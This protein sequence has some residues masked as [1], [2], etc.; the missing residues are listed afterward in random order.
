[1]G[2]ATRLVC[3]VALPR[4]AAHHRKVELFHRLDSSVETMPATPRGAL[5]LQLGE[6]ATPGPIDQR[7]AEFLLLGLTRTWISAATLGGPGG[8][9]LAQVLLLAVA[10]E[11]VVEVPR[12]CAARRWYGD[13]VRK[14]NP[15]SKFRS[16]EE[17]A[18]GPTRS[19]QVSG[20][21]AAQKP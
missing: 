11:R 16:L 5:P 21:S 1:M 10:L 17:R 9:R 20:V 14:K 3:V 4:P 13:Q 7:A 2:H 15:G 19:R 6:L 8:P 18:R 12:R